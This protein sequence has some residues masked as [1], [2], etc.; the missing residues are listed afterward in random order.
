M[1]GRINAREAVRQHWR[2][3]E[4]RQPSLSSDEAAVKEDGSRSGAAHL[5]TTKD[6][7]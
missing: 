7:L 2:A 4:K 3:E 1:T 5:Q 6:E